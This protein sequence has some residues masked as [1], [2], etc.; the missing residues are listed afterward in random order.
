MAETRFC[1]NCGEECALEDRFCTSCRAELRPTAS[2]PSG[3]GMRSG[4]GMPDPRD[5]LASMQTELGLPTGSLLADRYKILKELGAGGMGRVYLA[6]DQ[7][8]GIP[9]AVKVLRD[10]LKQDPGSVKRLVSEAKASIVL[11]HPNIVRLHNFEDGETAKF[12]V[13]EYV[14]GETLAHKIAREGKISEDGYAPDR[15]RSLPRPRASPTRKRSSI[16][17]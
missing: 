16:A 15:R 10:I 6:E 2:R 11:S 17:T 5:S 14:E 12:L 8:L 7:K 1:H 9:V 4:S 3:G 13:M